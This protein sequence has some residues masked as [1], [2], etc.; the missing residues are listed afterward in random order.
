MSSVPPPESV[1]P[2][3]DPREDAD[4]PPWRIWTAPAAVGMGL[5]VGIFASVLVALVS[6]ASGTSVAHPTP[7]VSLL[8]DVLFDAGFVAV[9][10]YLAALHGRPRPADFGYRRVSPALAVASFLTA[11]IGY[12]VVSAAYAQL[13]NLHG[14]D[15][16][17]NELGVSKSTAALVGAAIFVCVIA[18]IA[19]EF[20]FRG[21]IFGALRRWRIMVGGRNVGTVVAAILTGILFGLAHT[22]SASSQYLIPLGFLGFVL[23]L[24]RWR[25]RS[26]YPCMALHS[27]NNSLALGVSQ[28]HWGAGAILGLMVAALA[29]IALLTGP[30]SRADAAGRLAF[31]R[32]IYFLPMRQRIGTGLAVIALA[33]IGAS[34]AAAAPA[35]PGHLTLA[36]RYGF[37][38]EHQIVT[39]PGRGLNVHGEVRPYVPGQTVTV[40]AWLHGKLIKSAKLRVVRV[41]GYGLFVETI[42]SRDPGE[43]T[44]LVAH[45]ATSAQAAFSAARRYDVLDERVGFGSTGPFVQLIQQ[46]LAAL[47]FYLAQTGVYD[48]GTGLA[49]DAYHRLL[50][51]GVAQTLDPATITWL[52]N[53][54]GQFKLRFPSHGKHA[55]GNLSLQLLALAYGSRVYRIYPISS[56]KPSTPTILGDFHVYMKTPSYLPDGMYFSNFFWGG[57]AIHGYNPAPDYPASHGCMR[58]PIDD[59]ISIYNWLEIGNWVDVYY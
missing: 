3:P 32:L 49:I 29:A 33:L 1:A 12:Y 10:L 17:P 36:L 28:E 41:H 58:V 37:A 30:L 38:L 16:L 40:K 43:V 39:V 54:W 25:T 59:A 55:E 34:P 57:Y 14:S 7:A 46:R 47:H 26:L 23:C 21:F 35:P 11:G 19:E 15:K 13:I 52:L 24:L 8:S 6:K 5:C 2:A 48:A 22:G 44:V 4:E 42:S 53:G 20:F 27:V 9:A 51:Q 45:S 50:H 31:A 56:G 18:P